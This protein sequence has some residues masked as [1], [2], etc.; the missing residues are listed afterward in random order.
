MWFVVEQ[1]QRSMATI[2]VILDRALLELVDEIA[3]QK[4]VNR[5]ALIR[6]ALRSY[7]KRVRFEELERQESLAYEQQPDDVEDA[8]RWERVADWPDD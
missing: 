7:L 3:S 5:S 2:Q 8:R 4:R 1:T 6:E